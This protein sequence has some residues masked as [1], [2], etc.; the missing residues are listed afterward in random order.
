MNDSI[1]RI[2]EDAEKHY[3][4]YWGCDGRRCDECR[5]N[6]VHED[7]VT[8]KY[9][10]LLD[11]AMRFMDERQLPEGVEW[12]RFEDGELVRIG[13][14][15]E[16]HDGEIEKVLQVFIGCDGYTLYGETKEEFSEYGTPVDRPEPED[17]QEKIDAD[18]GKSFCEYFGHGSGICKEGGVCEAHGSDEP[19]RAIMIRD[20]LRRQREL[21]E[22]GAR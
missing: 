3:S 19:C 21:C 4:D 22:R 18:A 2:R 16:F 20:L 11:R 6:V 12:P 14:E 17:T 10:D 15:V 1:E 8:A 13:D 5:A 7:C 9:I